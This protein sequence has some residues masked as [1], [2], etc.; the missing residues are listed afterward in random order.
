MQTCLERIGIDKRPVEL[1]R[2]DYQSYNEYSVTHPN[3]LSDGDMKGKGT[4][5]GGHTHY[6]PDCNK[7][8]MT[9][10][11]HFNS[12]IDYS[13]FDTDNGG[14]LHDIEGREHIA[15]SGRNRLTG[16]NNYSAISQ[17]GRQS[18]TTDLNIQ[19]GQVVIN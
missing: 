7:A 13:N 3:A 16:I 12:P 6:L 18:V 8:V 11:G 15:F 14:G 17:Y 9:D 19:D 2:N 1:N 4:G 10:Y 5:H